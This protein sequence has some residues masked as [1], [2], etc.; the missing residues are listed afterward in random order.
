MILGDT[1]PGTGTRT[2]PKVL[3]AAFGIKFKLVGGF[4]SSADVFLTMERGEVE[5]ICKSLDSIKSRRPHWLADKTAVI[6]FQGGIRRHPDVQGVPLV[7]DLTKTE[8]NKRLIEFLYVGQDIGRPFVAPPGLPPERLKLLR[9]AFAA[10]MKDS[11]FAV[12]VTKQ[13]F[14]LEP[15]SGE[16][17]AAL[18]AKIYATPKP[19]VDKVGE[20][21]K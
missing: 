3:A 16:H 2:F 4:R 5:G 8:D 17:L 6:L 21:I 7:I 12:D 19:I 15:E 9:D 18:I 14:E 20:L 10:T 11:E 1:G 13:K